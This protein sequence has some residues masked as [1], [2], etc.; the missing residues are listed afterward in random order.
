LQYG[1]ENAAILTLSSNFK[2]SERLS[3][4][5]MCDNVRSQNIHYFITST[6][7]SLLASSFI[8]LTAKL[9][10]ALTSFSQCCLRNVLLNA[11]QKAFVEL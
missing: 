2:R 6:F 11:R 10:F 5:Q 8:L 3:K 1:F 9:A 4:H 7:P